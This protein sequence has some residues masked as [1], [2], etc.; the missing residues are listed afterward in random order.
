MDKAMNESK[1]VTVLI[2]CFNMEHK[3]PRLLESLY[4]QTSRNFQIY[5]IDDGSTD[6]S[7]KIIT[8]YI[9]KF[10][11]ININLN[12]ILKTNSGV[13]ST[14]NYGLKYVNTDFFCLPDA[15]DYLELNYI[16]ECSNYLI[17]NKDCSIVFTKCSVFY[18]SFK[19]YPCAYFERKDKF[20]I[21]NN[22]IVNDFIWEK[23]VY[24]C[25][26]YM[27]RTESFKKANG[28]MEIFCKTRGGQNFQMIF[29]LLFN[30]KVG[31]IDKPL[32]NYIIYK[33]SHSHQLK[34]T[35]ESTIKRIEIQKDILQH[36]I[37]GLNISTGEKN[38]YMEQCMQKYLVQEAKVAFNYCRIKSFRDSF[39]KIDPI[40][41]SSLYKRLNQL[42]YFFL[43]I[44]FFLRTIGYHI[45]SK[46]KNSKYIYL[47]QIIRLNFKKHFL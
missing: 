45:G 38:Y 33:I 39:S 46:I 21:Q 17:N 27:I 37:D 14:I 35:Y 19:K 13:A 43:I 41:Q 23:N 20:K 6:N 4:N 7:P 28:A 2:P 36:V 32:Y 12:Y 44:I 15:D 42:P 3:L 22:L 16:E 18:E 11:S 47:I 26:N 34:N 1:L 31:Y 10:H 8:E 29:P 9:D 30:Y 5:I 24:F 40:Y 25:P